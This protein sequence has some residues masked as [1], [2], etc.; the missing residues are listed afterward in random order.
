MA[1][2]FRSGSHDGIGTGEYGDLGA[3]VAAI[4]LD[5]EAR[6]P[7]LDAEPTFGKIREPHSKLMHL[8][9]A[10]EF[11]SGAQGTKEVLLR[12]GASKIGMAPFSS[13]SVFNFYLPDF[14]PQ[15][16]LLKAGL[17]SPEMM[18]GFSFVYH[19]FIIII[20]CLLSFHC[21]CHSRCHCRCLCN[22][23]VIQLSHLY[24]VC[25]S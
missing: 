2:A 18:L 12:S 19:L 8:M 4:M 10:M 21:R 23:F 5:P 24:H 3:T 16:S 22:V 14:Q 15:G 25:H 13:P 1:T 7:V 6:S 17:T 11:R 20:I 9:R